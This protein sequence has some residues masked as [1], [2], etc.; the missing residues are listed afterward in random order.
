M[1]KYFFFILLFG[2][3][4]LVG[5][6]DTYFPGHPDPPTTLPNTLEE[7]DVFVKQKEAKVVDLKPDNESRIYWA[8]QEKKKTKYAIVY[9][10][11]FTAS[12]VEGDPL[13]RNMGEKYGYN[14]YVPLLP[15]HGRA[16]IDAMK[17]YEP[18]EQIDAAMEAIAIG[19]MLGDSVILMSCST[20]ATLSV[21]AGPEDPRIAGYIMYSPN[22]E[23]HDRTSDLTTLPW[24]KQIMNITLGGEYNNV[25]YEKEA[26]KYWYA[27]YHAQSI[28]ALK[29]MIN[30]WMYPGQYARID[31]PLFLGYYHGD[32]VVSVKEM[33]RF[34]KYIRTPA[35]KKQMVDFPNTKHHVISSAMIS[36]DIESVEK[37][38]VAF[39]D[40]YFQ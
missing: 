9:L 4:Y 1:N 6:R 7:L 34:Y 33:K 5:P 13:H 26:Q 23:L 30:R 8:N 10:H 2:I 11:G 16:S 17:S 3:V 20:G 35:D 39:M 37:A 32:E 14:V 25:E 40:Q 15:S 18:D 21:I 29:A 27:K 12:W 38:T 36:Q 31:K 22:L 24:G 19:K 28:I